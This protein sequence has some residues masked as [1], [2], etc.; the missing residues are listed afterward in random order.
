MKSA[1]GA[2]KRSAGNDANAFTQQGACIGNKL[3]DSCINVGSLE[4]FWHVLPESPNLHRYETI[5]SV[6]QMAGWDLLRCNY[7]G[8]LSFQNKS[9]TYCSAFLVP[10]NRSHEKPRANTIMHVIALSSCRTVTRFG[11]ALLGRR[12]IALLETTPG[13]SRDSHRRATKSTY[14]PHEFY[15]RIPFRC[16]RHWHPTTAFPLRVFISDGAKSV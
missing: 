9:D 12:P 2:S 14:N 13:R 16:T 6:G 1:A 3:L 4:F 15:A 7:F 5:G 8:K 10:C 11:R